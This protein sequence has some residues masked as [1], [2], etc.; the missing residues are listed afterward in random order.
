MTKEYNKTEIKEMSRDASAVKWACQQFVHA[1][2]DINTRIDVVSYANERMMSILSDGRGNSDVYVRGGMK[3][4]SNSLYDDGVQTYRVMRTL[5]D[6]A[7]NVKSSYKVSKLEAPAAGTVSELR[8][9]DFPEKGRDTFMFPLDKGEGVFHGIL[10]DSSTDY[11]GRLFN[12]SHLKN[13]S[14]TA[15]TVSGRQMPDGQVRWERKGD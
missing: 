9:S 6:A 11:T 14:K 3:D 4:G 15:L 1:G 8:L 12:L 5:K 2:R 13:G 10:L 7:S